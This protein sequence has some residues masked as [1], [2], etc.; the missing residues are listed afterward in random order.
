MENDPDLSLNIKEYKDKL[1]DYAINQLNQEQ[2]NC[3]EL[4]YLQQKNYQEVAC[5]TGYDIGKVK[6]YIQNVKRNL[7]LLMEAAI[8]Q[9][10]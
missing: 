1:L 3:I 7:K 6:S 2:R 5:I 8:R 4:F 9:Y 10:E